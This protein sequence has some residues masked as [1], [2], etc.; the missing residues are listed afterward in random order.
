M[1]LS[2]SSE[3]IPF[4]EC[5]SYHRQDAKST[6]KSPTFRWPHHI[7]VVLYEFGCRSQ[8]ADGY[9]PSGA[10]AI[11]EGRSEANAGAS[12]EEITAEL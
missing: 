3:Y 11:V 12:L 5:P 7:T 4:F 9:E 6:G 2:N 10:T 8:S 1:P